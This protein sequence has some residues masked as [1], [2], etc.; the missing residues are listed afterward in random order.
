MGRG[1][2]VGLGV[3]VGRGVGV[4]VGTE[5][6]VAVGVGVGVGVGVSVGWG[7][8]VGTGVSVGIAATVAANRTSTGAS[9]FGVGASVGV[10]TGV[11][12]GSWARA[13]TVAG[14]FGVA[15]T[16]TGGCSCW[17]PKAKAMITNRRLPARRIINSIL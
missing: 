1:V 14:M 11:A 8:G 4:A 7:A 9:M 13:V 15:V 3:L 10:G 5:V 16:R 6:G 2:K 12:V 17:Q